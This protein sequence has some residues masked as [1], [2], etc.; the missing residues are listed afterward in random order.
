MKFKYI[1]RLVNFAIVKKKIQIEGAFKKSVQFYFIIYITRRC[2][3]IRKKERFLEIH[4]SSQ[5]LV[6]QAFHKTIAVKRCLTFQGQIRSGFY[7]I[8]MIF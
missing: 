1:K 7:M 8:L 4:P 2:T 5:I 3:E 6:P